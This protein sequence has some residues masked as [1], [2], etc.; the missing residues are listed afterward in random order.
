MKWFINTRKSTLL[1]LAGGVSILI[2]T[3]YI[4]HQ[5]FMALFNL[6]GNIGQSTP[7]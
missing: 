7:A 1:G 4:A 3:A 5:G 2:A 6:G